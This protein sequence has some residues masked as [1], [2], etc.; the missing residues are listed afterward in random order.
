[1]HVCVYHYVSVNVKSVCL[2]AFFCDVVVHVQFMFMCMY[3]L[4][5]SD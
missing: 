3:M 1:M 4:H 2:C 5:V